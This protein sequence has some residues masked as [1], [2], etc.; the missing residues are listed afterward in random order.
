MKKLMFFFV[1]FL[2]LVI[3]IT[4][5]KKDETEPV[6]PNPPATLTFEV[7]SSSDTI[8]KGEKVTYTIISNADSCIASLSSGEK[9][10]ITTNGT[11]S[12]SP[13]QTTIFNFAFYKGNFTLAKIYT[14]FVRDSTPKAPSLILNANPSQVSFDGKSTISFHAVDADS[15]TSNLPGVRGTSDS[16][17]T[18]SLQVSTTYTFKAWGK[19]G[20]KIDS[21]KISVSPQVLPTKTDLLV[22]RSWSDD[23]VWYKQEESAPWEFLF[24]PN[25]EWTIY[26]RDGMVN[27]YEPPNTLISA[28]TWSW[29]ENEEY[30]I[31]GYYTN[32]VIRLDSTTMILKR[33]EA[34]FNC[35]SG[36]MIVMRKY[37]H[38]Y[39]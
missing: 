15:V 19:G 38:K 4:G 11:K 7:K 12:F 1:A 17:Q 22:Y 3:L 24:F 31:T 23:T 37:I 39:K 25:L 14:T 8:S 9:Y 33:M 21:I 36:Y 26:S 35:P 34:C 16:I 30:L 6:A 27:V 29:T 5:C 28:G 10:K 20:T 2:F 13:N 18:P 32:T